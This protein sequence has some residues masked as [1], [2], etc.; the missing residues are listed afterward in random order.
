MYLERISES[1]I[2]GFLVHLFLIVITPPLLR[3]WVR[4]EIEDEISMFTESFSV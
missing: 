2:F 4:F 3:A 1:V